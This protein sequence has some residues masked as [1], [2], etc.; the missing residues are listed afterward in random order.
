M[1]DAAAKR[2]AKQTVNNLLLSLI[3][4]LGFVL[5][6]VLIVPRDDTPRHKPVDYV[7]IAADAEAASGKNL[8]EADLAQDWW[9]NSASWNLG[10]DGVATWYTGLVGGQNQFIG[11]TQAFDQNAT[12]LALQTT[13]YLPNTE[14]EATAAN[15]TKWKLAPEQKGDPTIWTIEFGS[16]AFVLKGTATD[17]EFVAIASQIEAEFSN[18]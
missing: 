10:A 6:L 5:V 15:W 4:C 9:A 8:F 12:W 18:D 1:S 7:S 11:V 17:A 2:R 3:A 13:G 14:G 16:Q